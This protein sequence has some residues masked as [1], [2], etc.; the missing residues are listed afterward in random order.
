MIFD[1]G[2][3]RYRALS[4]VRCGVY[5]KG[6]EMTELDRR[7]F[8]AT[9]ALGGALAA[10]PLAA[11]RAGACGFEKTA[12]A[13]RLAPRWKDMARWDREDFEG[14]VGTPFDIDGRMLVLEEIRRGPETPEEFREQFALVFESG[15][16]E[17]LESA[18]MP[19]RHPALGETE[20]FVSIVG[21][22]N[23]DDTAE[24]YFS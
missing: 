16:V 21:Y 14:L 17:G 23:A 18:I 24:I 4:A 7:A 8:M 11:G 5:W 22:M 10:S 15:K 9:A 20:L 12:G 2:I 19:V 13:G 1:G 6:N 3:R